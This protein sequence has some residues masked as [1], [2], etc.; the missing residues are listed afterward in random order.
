MTNI[1]NIVNKNISHYLFTIIIIILILIKKSTLKISIKNVIDS[2][3]K[4][5]L[6]AYKYL[7]VLVFNLYVKYFKGNYIL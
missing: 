4:Q 6:I 1:Y 5:S 7:G 2:F 3:C